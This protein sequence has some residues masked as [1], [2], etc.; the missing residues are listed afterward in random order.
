MEFTVDLHADYGFDLGNR[1]ILL[2]ADVFNLFNRQE[3]LDYDNWFERTP[4]TLNP[5]FGYP[6]NGGNGST[7]SLQ[8]PL[9]LRLGAR[10]DW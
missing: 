7:S 3:P 2:L 8:P 10:F 9:S 5:N 1:R 4:G 6:V